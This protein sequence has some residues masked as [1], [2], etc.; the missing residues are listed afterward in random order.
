VGDVLEDEP[1]EQFTIS[2]RM[3][4]GHQRRLRE[5]REKGNGFGYSLFTEEDEY[6]NTISA[7]YWKDGSE[8]LIKQNGKNPRILTPREAAR[9]QGYPEE[10]QPHSSKRHCYQQFGNSV[11]VPV[12]EA[13]CKEIVTSLKCKKKA[14]MGL[15]YSES[16]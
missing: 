5:H 14:D 11:S 3:W 6:V 8:I 12:I 4:E 1:D 13:I 7:R 2:D 15:V 9:I 10:F 16:V